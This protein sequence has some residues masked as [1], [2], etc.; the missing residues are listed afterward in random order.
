VPGG[1]FTPWLL[2][3]S[4]SP[5]RLR[6]SVPAGDDYWAGNHLQTVC[7]VGGI[8]IT[9]ARSLLASRPQ[10]NRF[11]LD[12]SARSV[13]DQV[14]VNEHE[15]LKQQ[16][17]DFT[18]VSRTDDVQGYIRRE[19][20]VS[21]TQEF[22]NARYV[23]CGP[24]AYISAVHSWLRKSDIPEASIH[25][26]KFFLQ[27]QSK[28][29]VA[30]SWK[31][32]GYKVGAALALL[33]GLWLLPDLAYLIPHHEHNPGHEKL[34]CSDCHRSAPGTL[35]QQLQAKLDFRLGRR[36]ADASFVFKPVNNQICM[37]CHKRSNDYHPSHR[38]LEPRFAAVRETLG[39]QLCYNC[40]REHN[41][42]RLTQTDPGFCASCHAELVLKKDPAQPTH[43]ELIKTQRWETC[44]GC[45]DFHNNHAW[46]A[47]HKL[48]EA[49]SPDRIRDYFLA[50][51]SPYGEVQQKADHKLPASS[52]TQ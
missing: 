40:H 37:D 30:R 21:T 1:Q 12:Y 16:C 48:T 8:G 45:H 39:P 35:R 2:Q 31:T 33:P 4:N 43:A 47:P 52:Q 42:V 27:T 6:I 11:H 38:F 22:P 32:Y 29:T 49:I 14:F 17:A 3:T 13:S 9:M 25:V 41:K 34:E 23:L 36:E 10:G 24:P 46:K 50:G 18:M 19:D 7:M 44:L 20:V 5:K 15:A 51:P 26:E 28:P